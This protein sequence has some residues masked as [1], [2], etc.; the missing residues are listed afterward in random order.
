[1]LPDLNLP[2]SLAGLLLALRPCFTGPS[3]RTFCGLVAGLAGQVR[4]RTVCGMLLGA[5]LSRCW[6]HDRAHY[7]FARAA[8]E[9]DEL[10][11]AVARLVVALLV[12]PGAAITVA[13]DDSLF[14][15]FGRK[16][17][18]V[19]WQHDG[20]S[21]ARNK[22]SFG[23]CFVTAGIIVALPFCAR[24]V[25]LPVLARLHVP[26]KGR[27]R[28]P[29]RQAAPA[30]TV[31]CAVELVTKLAGAF[32]GRQVH[33][34]A[35]AHYHG[36]ALKDL[37]AS[38]TWTTRLP[39]NAVLYALAPPRVRK[40][41]RPPRKGPRL[42]TAADLSAAASWTRAAVHAYGR[43]EAEDLAEVTCLWYGCLDIIRVR[44]ILARDAVTTLALV[45]TDLHAPAAALAERYAARWGI[46][47]AF[48]D[49]RNVLGAGEARTRARRAV[50]RTVPF[51]MLVH[52]L[53]ITW[54]AR[55]GYDPADISERRAGQPWYPAKAGPCF[56][57]MLTKLRRVMICAR[58]SGGSAAHPEPEQ[59]TAV[60]AA[61]H[62][63][64]A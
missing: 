36:P 7:F 23:N 26:G 57:D 3:S 62:A 20:S 27:A 24:P 22:L 12:P 58:I 19:A 61:W 11:L 9:L 42:G 2:A 60:L 10:G 53:V 47:Q 35:D 25:C 30:S 64:A 37:P 8:W 49:A 6:P 16:V 63:A 50:E 52:S 14:R 46:E 15:R 43:D 40:P 54:Y 29:R 4:R 28:K 13:V 33:V 18:G 21:P 59:I 55:H 5:G 51:A 34:V 32:P 48:F 45:T 44:V 17:F 38:V 56:E 31:S 1:M 39:K 41:G